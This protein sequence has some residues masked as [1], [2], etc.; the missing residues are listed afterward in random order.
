MS[1]LRELYQSVILDHNRKPRNFREPENA[2]RCARGDN[3][4]C[5]DKLMVFLTVE[6]DVV[7]DAAFTG[8][9]CAIST[10]SASLMT[11]AIKGRPRDEVERLF[12][13]FHTLVTSNPRSPAV[14]GQLGKLAVFSGVREFPIRVKCATLA[15]HT[16]NAALS[17]SGEIATTE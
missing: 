13:G 3:P 8:S 6:A 16:M 4:L 7:T 14:T 9:G 11:E 17:E 5:G 2:N 15:W 12:E 10:A 1:D